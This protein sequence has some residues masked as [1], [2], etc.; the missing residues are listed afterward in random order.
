MICLF[1]CVDDGGDLASSIN[2]QLEKD[3]QLMNG[4]EKGD[5]DGMENLKGGKQS[6]QDCEFDLL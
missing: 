4:Q 2:Q 1:V 5:A 6:M 3:N